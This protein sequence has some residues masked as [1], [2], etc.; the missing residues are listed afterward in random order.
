MKKAILP[1]I[2]PLIVLGSVSILVLNSDKLNS[3]EVIQYFIITAIVAFGVY[4]GV[5]RITSQKRGQPT[6]DELSKKIILKASSLSYFLSIYLWLV[7][8][9]LTDKLKIETDIMFGW[10]ILGMAISFAL[11]WIYFRFKGVKDE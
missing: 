1:I 10:G 7:I 11:S 5:S 6:E 9:Y 8:M 4:M 2:I 3:G